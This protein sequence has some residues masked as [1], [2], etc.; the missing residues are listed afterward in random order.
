MRQESHQRGLTTVV[1]HPTRRGAAYNVIF[2]RTIQRR[3]LTVRI[4]REAVV[5]EGIREMQRDRSTLIVLKSRWCAVP[6]CAMFVGL[7]KL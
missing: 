3:R 6:K 4:G 5:R 7:T 1:I 2:Y